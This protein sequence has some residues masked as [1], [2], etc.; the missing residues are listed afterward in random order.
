MKKP[1][2]TKKIDFEKLSPDD[3]PQLK[4]ISRSTFFDAFNTQN[5]PED[6]HSY[7]NEAFSESTLKNE[8]LESNSEFY[9]ARIDNRIVGYFK[10]NFEKAQ[11][12]LQDPDGMELE[13][14][15][16]LKEHQNQKIGQTMLDEVIEMAIQRK[17]RYLWL[18]V[19]EK[20]EKAIKFYEKNRFEFAGTHDFWVGNDQQTDRIMKLDLQKD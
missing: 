11:T 17:M 7:I 2:I 1:A 19:W 8:L 16:V 15:Y 3:L 4:E 14:I 13:R 20:N 6:L 18:G 12:D 10:I 5:N 9:F